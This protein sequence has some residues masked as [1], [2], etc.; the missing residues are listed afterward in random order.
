MT[1]ETEGLLN[2]KEAARVLGVTSNTL[3]GWRFNGKVN[4]TYVKL[5][6]SIRYRRADLD[7]L[8]NKGITKMQEVE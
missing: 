6:K 2:G 1:E 7:D 4:L 5:G 3:A 8:I